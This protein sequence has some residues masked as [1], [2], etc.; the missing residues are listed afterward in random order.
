VAAGRVR[1]VASSRVPEAPPWLTAGGASPWMPGGTVTMLEQAPARPA[2]APA[3][4][5]AV[6]PRPP[7]ALPAPP[8]RSAP[9]Y[10]EPAGADLEYHERATGPHQYPRRPAPAPPPYPEHA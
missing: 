3:P 5:R 6:S 1:E 9:T 10:P 4:S 7:L 2:V 8:S